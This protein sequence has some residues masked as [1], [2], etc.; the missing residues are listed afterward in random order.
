MVT[1]LPM[2]HRT[3]IITAAATLLVGVAIALRPFALGLSLVV[4]AADVRGVSRHI[5]D[6]VTVSES[7]RLLYVPISAGATRARVYVPG[8]QSRQTVL[9]A[10]GLHPAGIDEPRLVALARELAKSNV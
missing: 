9:L 8:R 5:A 1:E 10:S 6:L 2:R 3:V 4:R 7:E